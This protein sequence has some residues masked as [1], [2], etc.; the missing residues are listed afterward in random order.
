VSQIQAT[1]AKVDE[2]LK[3]LSISYN[4]KAQAVSAVVRKKS[5]NFA[6][7]D[8]EDF[9]PAEVVSKNEFL[10]SEFLV[11]VVAV[12]SAAAEAGKGPQILI[13]IC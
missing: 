11:T 6:T 1:A 7:S 9:L 13:L 8:F 12:I 3:K 4:E 2:E 10:D 5:T